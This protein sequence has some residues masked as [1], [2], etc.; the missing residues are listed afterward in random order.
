MAN[1]VGLL[2]NA[3]TIDNKIRIDRENLIS[4][5]KGNLFRWLDP[6]KC[7]V[8]CGIGKKAVGKIFKIFC[9]YL[10][11]NFSIHA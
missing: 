8:G 7:N 11:S 5:A 4:K 1:T 9:R 3:I 10:T 2:S 6:Q